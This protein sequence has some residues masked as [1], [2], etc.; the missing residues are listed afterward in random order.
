MGEAPKT[1]SAQK[2]LPSLDGAH[3]SQPFPIIKGVTGERFLKM[4]LRFRHESEP[5]AQ[6]HFGRISVV[7][8]S[9]FSAGS[10]RYTKMIEEVFHT[11]RTANPADAL[12]SR[13]V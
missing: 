11:Q 1:K 7:V 10:F 9:G 3:Q 8:T 6:V 13:R 12:F 5:S 4:P 2:Y